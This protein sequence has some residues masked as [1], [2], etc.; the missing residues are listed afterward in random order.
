MWVR[1]N[2]EQLGVLWTEVLNNPPGRVLESDL[3]DTV[4]TYFIEES[5]KV[6]YVVVRK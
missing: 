6:T 1:I 2:E 3:E 4:K 5:N